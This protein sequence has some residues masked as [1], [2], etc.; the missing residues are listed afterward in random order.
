MHTILKVFRKVTLS[1]RLIN[2]SFFNVNCTVHKHK[3]TSTHGSHASLHTVKRDH[4]M[5]YTISSYPW[6]EHAI[7][8]NP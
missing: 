6:R 1:F 3:W 5:D 7:V 8:A 2:V 4:T